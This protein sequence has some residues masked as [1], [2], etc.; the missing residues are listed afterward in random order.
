MLDEIQTCEIQ[1]RINRIKNIVTPCHFGRTEVPRTFWYTWFLR[2]NRFVYSNLRANL[3]IY[4]EIA[5]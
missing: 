5:K 3:R 1:R 4:S 2:H